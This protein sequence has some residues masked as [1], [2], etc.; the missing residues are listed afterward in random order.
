MRDTHNLDDHP[1]FRLHRTEIERQYRRLLEEAITERRTD[2]VDDLVSDDVLM[3]TTV[4]P[5][6]IRGPDGLKAHL[7]AYHR[8]F[9]DLVCDLESVVTSGSTLAAHWTMTG[10]HEGP[11][12][13]IEPTGA[14]I[15]V[16]GMEISRFENRRFVER[17]VLVDS[18]GLLEQ[19]GALESA[20][21][22]TRRHE[23]PWG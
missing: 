19:L 20:G 2:V 18:L 9:P 1:Y 12:R 8:A 4:G 6:L 16:Q 22:E 10:T 21:F 14:K 23:T 7:R 11:F 13:G 15:S 17:W 5:E 3:H